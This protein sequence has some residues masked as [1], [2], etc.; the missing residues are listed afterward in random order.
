M[1]L[2][3]RSHGEGA[4]LSLVDRYFGTVDLFLVGRQCS[5]AFLLVNLGFTILCV[6]VRRRIL[7][8][9]INLVRRMLA[10]T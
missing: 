4:L 3:L 5:L 8:D 1:T 2:P 9:S 6:V 10:T 7:I